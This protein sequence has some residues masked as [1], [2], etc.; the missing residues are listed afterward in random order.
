[1][2]GETARELTVSF[3][4]K[5]IFDFLVCEM[6]VVLPEVCRGPSSFKCLF[7][8]MLENLSTTF[9]YVGVGLEALREGLLYSPIALGKVDPRLDSVND[10]IST[11]GANSFL[12]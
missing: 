11:S 6:G 3:A 8:I 12:V 1:M 2:S 4:V 9:S 7:P 10:A 5:D